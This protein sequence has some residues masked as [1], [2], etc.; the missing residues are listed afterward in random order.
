[1]LSAYPE[2]PG[3]LKYVAIAMVVINN[4]EH[5]GSIRSL[6]HFFNTWCSNLALNNLPVFSNHDHMCF[7]A[8]IC[9]VRLH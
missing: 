8:T 9:K 2:Q 3:Q 4:G 7:D 1:V 5:C 6:A